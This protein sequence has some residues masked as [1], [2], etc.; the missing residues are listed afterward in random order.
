M[1]RLGQ[2]ASEMEAASTFWIRVAVHERSTRPSAQPDVS[3]A[4]VDRGGKRGKNEVSVKLRQASW[5]IK[6]RE[7]DEDRVRAAQLTLGKR[8][9][10][11]REYDELLR[12]GGARQDLADEPGLR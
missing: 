2:G 5:A 4:T 3:G 7:R 6:W 12:R 1:T 10:G 9:V 8:G 11:A